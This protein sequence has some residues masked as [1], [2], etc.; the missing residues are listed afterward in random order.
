MAMV[1]L[2]IDENTREGKIV[3]D[4]IELVAEKTDDIEIIS[5]VKS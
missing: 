4:F 3:L 2:E 5:R 1:E